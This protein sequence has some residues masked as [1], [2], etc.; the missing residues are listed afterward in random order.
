M[1]PWNRDPNHDFDS[2]VVVINVLS[3]RRID[4]KAVGIKQSL[5]LLS[6]RSGTR[7][8]ITDDLRVRILVCFACPL[9]T[10]VTWY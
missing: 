4:T 6:R 7:L 2:A 1:A 9:L 5:A 8:K 3:R 10:D